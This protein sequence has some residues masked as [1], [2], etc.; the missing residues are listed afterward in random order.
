MGELCA[1]G[2]YTLRGYY[3]AAEHNA[4][5]FTEDGFYRTG[6]LAARRTLS[7]M[8]CYT[9]DGR[10]KDLINRG[11]E[12]VNVEEMEMVLTNHPR[13]SE[14]AL[15]AMPDERLGERACAFLVSTSDGSIELPELRHW[16]E[17]QGVAKYKWPERL[18]WLDEMPRAS[19]VGKINKR[20]LRDRASTLGPQPL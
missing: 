12:K 2:P 18:V 20:E 8:T 13:I 10:I 17:Q 1:R 16:L 6:D 14:A 7:G 3:D 5:A 19:D 4:R 9:I 11:G 15:V